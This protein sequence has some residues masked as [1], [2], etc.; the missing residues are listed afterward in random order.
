M[1]MQRLLDGQKSNIYNAG[2]GRGY[3][4]KE[5]LEMVKSVTGLTLNVK[6]VERRPG[7][8]GALYASIDKI[9]KDFS[10]E[11]KYGLK[12]IIESAYA[13]HKKYPRG[14]AKIV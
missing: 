11:P 6:Y 1:A 13:W 5:V 2:I 4:N 8:A 10:W 9:K 14:Y 12:E 7:D 3:S